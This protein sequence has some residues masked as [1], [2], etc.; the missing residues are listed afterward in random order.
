MTPAVGPGPDGFL[1]DQQQDRRV[2]PARRLTFLLRDKKV[3]KEARPTSWPPVAVPCA[4][5]VIFSSEHFLETLK[6]PH[7]ARLR[8]TGDLYRQV[9]ALNSVERHPHKKHHKLVKGIK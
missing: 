2:A 7:P 4:A 8:H 9:I 1:P 5:S 6:I 3:S